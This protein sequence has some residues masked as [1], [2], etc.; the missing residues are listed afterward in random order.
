MVL[1]AV[2]EY[3]LREE[4]KEEKPNA[5][6]IWAK[7]SEF[8]TTFALSKSG[9]GGTQTHLCPPLFIVNYLSTVFNIWTDLLEMSI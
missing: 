6:K 1:Q 5:H 2:E 4:E 8:R 9:G 3:L 7:F